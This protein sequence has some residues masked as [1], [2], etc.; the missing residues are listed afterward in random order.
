[1]FLHDALLYDSDEDFLATVVPFLDDGVACGETAILAADPR[2]SRMVVDAVR[3]P[4]A[5]D[6]I[7][8]A[9]EAPLLTLR[10]NRE[11]FESAAGRTRLVGQIPHAHVRDDWHG[12]AR[13]EAAVNDCYEPFAVSGMCP[14]DTRTTADAVL[15]DVLLTHPRIAG[16]H[17]PTHN[18]DYVEPNAFLALLAEGDVNPLERTE[19]RF[20][21]HDPLPDNVRESVIAL[22]RT[23]GLCAR[24]RRCLGLAAREVVI[25]AI[26]HGRPPVRVSGWSDAGRVAVA[27]RDCGTGPDDPYAGLLPLG[28]SGPSQELGLHIAYSVC[29]VTMTYSSDA[30]TVH[31][32]TGGPA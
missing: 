15:D 23:A 14:Y 9:Y 4:D 8:G 3:E 11:R 21:L 29:D 27:V 7:A 18:W 20:V 12:W 32:A 1:M 19:P 5:V 16:P 31:L 25:N 17:G 26:E 22:G 10:L 13:Y 2:L 24:D 28:G 30:F 6:V